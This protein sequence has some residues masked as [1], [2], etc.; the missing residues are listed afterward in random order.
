MRTPSIE[1]KKLNMAK[2]EIQLTV[3]EQ[4]IAEAQAKVQELEA[5]HN[6]KLEALQALQA[7]L[8]GLTAPKEDNIPSPFGKQ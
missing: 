3:L 2:V 6:E 4:R 1:I 7:E 5:K 8:N